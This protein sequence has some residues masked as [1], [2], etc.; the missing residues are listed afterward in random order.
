MKKLLAAMLVGLALSAVAAAA[1]P[2]PAAARAAEEK[3]KKGPFHSRE[4]AKREAHR[5]ERQGYHTRVKGE[6][7]RWWVY[8]WFDSAQ[9]PV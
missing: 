8:Y 1:T 6:G 7:H 3:M 9:L 2:A 5:L 4:E